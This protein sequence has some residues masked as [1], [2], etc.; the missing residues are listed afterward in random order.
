MATQK[1]HQ[2]LHET[3]ECDDPGSLLKRAIDLIDPPRY[4]ADDDVEYAAEDRSSISDELRPPC[5]SQDTLFK[6]NESPVELIDR[7]VP[8]NQMKPKKVQ[9]KESSCHQRKK[10]SVHDVMQAYD[11]LMHA[12]NI[13]SSADANNE[14]L[15]SSASEESSFS[16]I[17]WESIQHYADTYRALLITSCLLLEMLPSESSNDSENSDAEYKRYNTTRQMSCTN[18]LHVPTLSPTIT[19]ILLS[20]SRRCILLL[21]SLEKV[22][23]MKTISERHS[24]KKFF[25]TGGDDIDD[26]ERSASDLQLNYDWHDDGFLPKPCSYTSRKSTTSNH[27]TA[28]SII[29]ECCYRPHFPSKPPSSKYEKTASTKDWVRGERLISMSLEDYQYF[30][31]ISIASDY[32]TNVQDDTLQGIVNQRVSLGDHNCGF[33]MPRP[34]EEKGTTAKYNGDESQSRNHGFQGE[35]PVVEDLSFL[36]LSPTA[37]AQEEVNLLDIMIPSETSNT[38]NVAIP[39]RKKKQKMSHDQETSEH[40]IREDLSFH[41]KEGFLLLVRDNQNMLLKN[42]VYATVR[43]FT[44]LFSLLL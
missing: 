15:A 8:P 27:N 2:V 20:T 12:V 32:S 37:L 41:R 39:K 18:P 22:C 35:R 14:K 17:S 38:T 29:H 28:T 13:L 24:R 19:G 4:R 6:I 36:N 33:V 44:A 21:R 43:Y 25:Y 42:R 11:F 30:N 40:I 26:Y 23:G 34:R 16:T 9:F 5:N 1:C 10:I 3:S 31:G 7:S